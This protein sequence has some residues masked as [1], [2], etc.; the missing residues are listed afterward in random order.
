MKSMSKA[1]PNVDLNSKQNNYQWGKISI[2][3]NTLDYL[4]RQD[5]QISMSMPECDNINTDGQDEE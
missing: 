4:I 5:D 2:I 3:M 1:H